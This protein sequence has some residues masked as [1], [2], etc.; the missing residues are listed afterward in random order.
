MA[1]DVREVAESRRGGK[2]GRGRGW[3]AWHRPLEQSQQPGKVLEVAGLVFWLR[4]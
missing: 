3:L 2:G 4:K 1:P